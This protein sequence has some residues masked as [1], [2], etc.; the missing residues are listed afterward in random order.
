I[1]GGDVKVI[2]DA[3]TTINSELTKTNQIDASSFQVFMAL[4]GSSDTARETLLKNASEITG[5]DVKVIN[6][7]ITRINSELTTNKMDVSS[8][9]VFMALAGSSDTARAT[10]FA[11]AKKILNGDK[12]FL[13][14]IVSAVEGTNI[15][16]FT[17]VMSILS[18]SFSVKRAE[19]IAGTKVVT[20]MDSAGN[21]INLQINGNPDAADFESTS[22]KMINKAESIVASSGDLSNE[23]NLRRMV[24]ALNSDPAIKRGASSG[25]Q[26]MIS[27]ADK[28]T[29]GILHSVS[30]V[31]KS[32]TIVK[33][34]D[35]GNDRTVMISAT[36]NTE[37][38]N[39]VA[40]AFDNIAVSAGE[41]AGMENVGNLD[42]F[43]VLAETANLRN[44]SL[45]TGENISLQVIDRTT[46]S[47]IYSFIATYDEAALSIILGDGSGNKLQLT[48]STIQNDDFPVGGLFS[49]IKKE[50][51]NYTA[52]QLK[53]ADLSDR[54]T[55]QK[56]AGHLND[57]MMDG[58]LYGK[59]QISAS[60]FK[61]GEGEVPL[62]T[63]TSTVA[64]VS[65]GMTVRDSSGNAAMITL[66][67]SQNRDILD[68]TMF[69]GSG[70]AVDALF[71]N[72]AKAEQIVKSAGDLSKGAA[73]RKIAEALDRSDIDLEFDKKQNFYDQ[74]SVTIGS[75][76]VSLTSET[77]SV[78]SIFKDASG[79]AVLISSTGDRED[80]NVFG[81][82]MYDI[83]A[84]KPLISGAD[85]VTNKEGMVKLLYNARTKLGEERQIG[86][87]VV[88]KETGAVLQGGVKGDDIAVT[89]SVGG[90]TGP[91][92]VTSFEW[93]DNKRIL[94]AFASGD[95]IKI[96]NNGSIEIASKIIMS[97]A[98]E[99]ANKGYMA[100]VG[101]ITGGVAVVAAFVGGFFTVGVTWAAIPV[102]IGSVLTGTMIGAAGGYFIMGPALTGFQ[103]ATI[104]GEGI[105]KGIGRDSLEFS[106]SHTLM[107][108]LAN[109]AAVNG[110]FSSFV[111]ESANLM[112]CFVDYITFGAATSGGAFEIHKNSVFKDQEMKVFAG[113]LVMDI[114]LTAGLGAFVKSIIRGSGKAISKFSIRGVGTAVAKGYRVTRTGIAAMTF[115]GVVSGTRKVMASRVVKMV[116][117]GKAVK[118]RA[119]SNISTQIRNVKAGW[120]NV[121]ARMKKIGEVG[122]VQFGIL[123]TTPF[124][125]L[126]RAA[127]GVA[128]AAGHTLVFTAGA[129]STL[130]GGIRSFLP[131]LGGV[132][133]VRGILGDSSKLFMQGWRGSLISTATSTLSSRLVQM[134]GAGA[135]HVLSGER[136]LSAR[137]AA[138]WS[139]LA[140][141]GF[142]AGLSVI[143]DVSVSELYNSGD[144]FTVGISIFFI[145]L[146][147][148]GS[149]K[150]M[151]KIMNN[152][153]SGARRY[154]VFG[155]PIRVAAKFLGG[156]KYPAVFGGKNIFG[157]VKAGTKIWLRTFSAEAA[158]NSVFQIGI[159]MPITLTGMG[160]FTQPLMKSM[161]Y[162]QDNISYI[163][164]WIGRA[165]AQM[166]WQ[167]GEQDIVSS[168]KNNF[169]PMFIVTFHL[170]G[171]F[172][173]AM[174]GHGG[175]AA[176]ESIN[177]GAMW[178]VGGP[179]MMANNVLIRNVMKLARG[180]KNTFSYI[181]G[182][183]ERSIVSRGLGSVWE[184]GIK[185][186]L[187]GLGL[188]AVGI[189]A[190]TAEYLV[191]MFDFNG[192]AN[193]RGKVGTTET[194]SDN[195]M[196][197]VRSGGSATEVAKTLSGEGYNNTAT[198]EQAITLLESGENVQAATL[199][200]EFATSNREVIATTV[201]TTDI[202]IVETL[203]EIN[204][205]IEVGEAL[206]GYTDDLETLTSL[207]VDVSF[208]DLGLEEVRAIGSYMS[209]NPLAKVDLS[210]GIESLAG[211]T[212][213]VGAALSVSDVSI[214]GRL[215]NAADISVRAME[216]ITLAESAGPASIRN[217]T[218]NMSMLDIGGRGK[219]NLSQTIANT[220]LASFVDNANR[221]GL[222][223]LGVSN[224]M[225]D[226]VKAMGVSTRKDFANSILE[227]SFNLERDDITQQISLLAVASTLQT[228]ASDTITETVLNDLGTSLQTVEASN[229]DRKE[230]AQE[231]KS[232]TGT[233]SAKDLGKRVKGIA[234]GRMLADNKAG[235]AKAHMEELG[236]NERVIGLLTGREN[237]GLA[238]AVGIA[239][240]NATIIDA[241]SVNDND[242]ARAIERLA[243]AH[244]TDI[245]VQKKLINAVLPEERAKR[246]EGM[247]TELTK[248]NAGRES[249][250]MA[251]SMFAQSFYVYST[252]GGHHFA[253]QLEEALLV[254]NADG[255]VDSFSK[256]ETGIMRDQKTL[257]LSQDFEKAGGD[258]R[259][260]AILKAY[261]LL[262]NK[263]VGA[264]EIKGS[265][266]TVFGRVKDRKV[267]AENLAAILG[268]NAANDFIARI[269]A[270]SNNFD[271]NDGVFQEIS[272]A[273]KSELIHN[274]QLFS[275]DKAD[276]VVKALTELGI[277]ELYAV[278]D[279]EIAQVKTYLLEK[280]DVMQGNQAFIAYMLDENNVNNLSDGVKTFLAEMSGQNGMLEQSLQR[281]TIMNSV[282]SKD[283]ET[284]KSLIGKRALDLSLET[285]ISSDVKLLM[286][287][288][289]PDQM[290]GDFEGQGEDLSYE[291]STL[292]GK[293]ITE[294]ISKGESVLTKRKAKKISDT[295]NK[296]R[297]EA[298]KKSQE[299][300]I[301]QAKYEE[302]LNEEKKLHE[303]QRKLIGADIYKTAV[304]AERILEGEIQNIEKTF[305]L[306]ISEANGNTLRDKMISYVT[307]LNKE[308]KVQELK[309]LKEKVSGY[310]KS[311]TAEWKGEG[312]FSTE[313]A[314]AAIM[315]GIVIED[316]KIPYREQLLAA[317]SMIEGNRIAELATGEGK[318]I[319]GWMVNYVR[320]LSGKGVI[321]ASS[322]SDLAE[323]GYGTD[324]KKG[325]KHILGDI[326]GLNVGLVTK[327]TLNEERGSNYNTDA[328]GNKIDVTYVDFGQ[329]AFDVI[330]DS[331]VLSEKNKGGRYIRTKE[332]DLK[333]IF[334][335]ID[336]IDSVLIDQ[337]LTSFIMSGGQGAINLEDKIKTMVA[338]EVQKQL[339]LEGTERQEAQKD[340]GVTARKAEEGF[341]MRYNRTDGMVSLSKDKAK[342]NE[343]V[344]NYAM[345]F[346]QTETRQ[347]IKR[348]LQNQNSSLTLEEI[349][350]AF[351]ALAEKAML[352]ILPSETTKELSK[353]GMRKKDILSDIKRAAEADILYS[354][355]RDYAL[356]HGEIILVS[357]TTGFT[358]E[359]Q[360]LQDNL[361][362]FLEAKEILR[363][364]GKVEGLEMK[365]GS[366]TS[367]SLTARDVLTFFGDVS[368]MTG[369]A[370]S[371]RED[372]ALFKDIY[373]LS[374][375]NI[376]RNAVDKRENRPDEIYFSEGERSEQLKNKI[377]EAVNNDRPVLIQVMNMREADKLAKE[378]SEWKID[379]NGAET[380]LSEGKDFQVYDAR[381]ERT[382]ENFKK[383]AAKDG[384]ITIA[385][386]VAG[387][388]TDITPDAFKKSESE[389]AK[390]RSEH[391][392]KEHE[393]LLAI[394]MGFHNN[395]RV[396]DQFAGRAG[397][398][399]E[400]GEFVQMMLIEKGSLDLAKLEKANS[401]YAW[402]HFQTAN[403]VIFKALAIA[404][405][406]AGEGS[407]ET[408]KTEEVISKEKEVIVKAV[409]ETQN[410]LGR[411]SIRKIRSSMEQG[412]FL[413]NFQLKMRDERNRLDNKLPVFSTVPK[414]ISDLVSVSV[415]E[416]TEN[417]KVNI[418]KLS[419]KLKQNTGLTLTEEELSI[420]KDERENL[421]EDVTENLT[422]LL[423]RHY[424]RA[425][426]EELI[427]DGSRAFF[428]EAEAIR[429]GER[430]DKDLQEAF[431]DAYKI[432]LDHISSVY[433]DVD[434]VSAF[435]SGEM[436]KAQE[437]SKIVDDN[438]VGTY[439]NISAI[440]KTLG[441]AS[442]KEKDA[443][444]KVIEKFTP[445]Q[446]ETVQKVLETDVDNAIIGLQELVT[447]DQENRTKHELLIQ[448]LEVIYDLVAERYKVQERLGDKEF[449][450]QV[451]APKK[452]LGQ[453]VRE[454]IF[455]VKTAYAGKEFNRQAVV[456]Q[457]GSATVLNVTQ[458]EK[459]A[460]RENVLK[461]STIVPDIKT[462]TLS[463]GQEVEIG[464]FAGTADSSGIT[465]DDIK[466]AVLS[467]D[468]IKILFIY[469]PPTEEDVNDAILAVLEDQKIMDQVSSAP[470]DSSAIISLNVKEPEASVVK[471]F[472]GEITEGI[473]NLKRDIEIAR[474]DAAKYKNMPREA[475]AKEA[476]EEISK[477]KVITKEGEYFVQTE[478][479]GKTI[480]AKKYLDEFETRM[481]TEQVFSD[482]SINVPPSIMSIFKYWLNN[483]KE[484]IIGKTSSLASITRSAWEDA[485]PYIKAAIL[486]LAAYAVVSAILE[487]NIPA[488]I[489]ALGASLSIIP[490][491][492]GLAIRGRDEEEIA[493]MSIQEKAAQVGEL[494]VLLPENMPIEEKAK[495]M[496]GIVASSG[497]LVSAGQTITV[498]FGDKEYTLTGEG[499]SV[500]DMLEKEMTQEEFI[501][502]KE[503][504]DQEFGGMMPYEITY[505]VMK[506]GTVEIS[507]KAAIVFDADGEIEFMSS[508]ETVS[509][510]DN[511]IFRGHTHPHIA[512]DTTEFMADAVSMMIRE[513]IYGK[514]MTEYMVERAGPGIFQMRALTRT[515]DEFTISTIVNGE[516]TQTEAI[517]L[518]I[519]AIAALQKG[520]SRM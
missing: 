234:V 313:E 310:L 288:A 68:K 107:N 394:S 69:T 77:M 281:L 381:K 264:N 430:S 34:V 429:R 51:Q 468:N 436:K 75:N 367:R 115:K 90:E 405:D 81:L 319:V 442:L 459:D 13:S 470:A 76:T 317:V 460:I 356:R 386:A 9:Q 2:N 121:T 14:N 260:F 164:N 410:I 201:S 506:D 190:S 440:K 23:E 492:G 52:N 285:G 266:K 95:Q 53:Y 145:A 278:S 448:D 152:A 336:E 169:S 344:S 357:D 134:A 256:R 314:L 214:K 171:P 377:E 109:N 71:G 248:T 416:A 185:E 146:T 452:N 475:K 463:N 390:Y 284:L 11:N 5:G 472:K 327:N 380:I 19:Q 347:K 474:K 25:I 504:A 253:T 384:M 8:F 32:L 247:I 228:E 66:S 497:G 88:Q 97:Q 206:Q 112:V 98:A 235:E 240:N 307:T 403:P 91:Q 379:K 92:L 111:F 411:S 341:H 417:G 320:A 374:I 399:G 74:I 62:Y 351:D 156:L 59:D 183:S 342:R 172:I 160:K 457:Q 518:D 322:S 87:S 482:I 231:L 382:A 321:S 129:V 508:T 326:M 158:L 335:T 67:V 297:E 445:E 337:A 36:V 263:D 218:S 20:L 114:V 110:G 451:E 359:G 485:N 276:T 194:R 392:G 434:H 94:N 361:H 249:Y 63:F 244:A 78:S 73:L 83:L 279:K 484:R 414:S 368:G 364:D 96:S 296:K 16:S 315:M 215:F 202:A 204:T 509:T 242:T 275:K 383:E 104:N 455:G 269:N 283:V 302:Y 300:G 189:K 219:I 216:T 38:K 370:T 178:V 311:K 27:I 239:L 1:T 4:A 299:K 227:R 140:Y 41:L 173:G 425:A 385:T 365:G 353:E 363:A 477:V 196:N 428:V 151:G 369:T 277:Y 125:V 82:I 205:N 331:F 18:T 243:I 130:L 132:A 332:S 200:G 520:I 293:F 79:N 213:M 305:N 496:E 246:L 154:S 316:G 422:D 517:D 282:G 495:L 388:G 222:V 441:I 304:D 329:L 418:E 137:N 195:I 255:L 7:A 499:E 415:G 46:N 60:V 99:K 500:L 113:F 330:H 291:Q 93:T 338:Y 161:G 360:R 120:L 286:T 17:V 471:I 346:R 44:T 480:P 24:T 512:T 70:T 209:N 198:F 175:K 502:V 501:K 39:A 450:K 49:T 26:T 469:I 294:S 273:I 491:A 203:A 433:M 519:T 393:G 217:L 61:S 402:E 454:R 349:D 355:N 42:Q 424:T 148:V 180:M 153:A 486:S 166:V 409:T 170:L 168:I 58:V 122:S 375:D 435:A 80:N 272:D 493:E 141:T 236:V 257:D 308:G 406:N 117:F 85:D 167:F 157:S 3:I 372:I 439:R 366:G 423:T 324:A 449:L 510:D 35:V 489:D 453:R 126:G 478:L 186:P 446:R 181:S 174:L 404:N 184:E 40:Y 466:Q 187:I 182:G 147:G 210:S 401:L 252:I 426:Q 456:A 352:G 48:A 150:V 437:S 226:A 192:N 50:M 55:F 419:K 232:Q 490:L 237:A 473:D 458:E 65:L 47:I 421:P 230:L 301:S 212:A 303:K 238:K 420:T 432:F 179:H 350:G 159:L 447:H 483:V 378:M 318:T 199:L 241:F 103:K 396:R 274:H 376:G 229:L 464:V 354:L 498:N 362:Q 323:E 438:T 131:G 371:F 136:I 476:L 254:T 12:V 343:I 37:T 29:G 162:D 188:Q 124:G 295:L 251:M 333:D 197:I 488:L 289:H 407:S 176:G 280:E 348:V 261:G 298:Y 101:A 177:A 431:N 271:A 245:G 398:N 135:K 108:E 462:V 340:S 142:T 6:D 45:G 30:I 155:K 328:E 389:R 57:R 487:I 233:F 139:M 309:E 86:I 400:N 408:E 258:V 133:K 118:V 72:M 15:N 225:Q 312:R 265:L 268:A 391:Y 220:A 250:K 443:A 465:E 325:A 461:K 395:V 479:Y 444:R 207:G 123:T 387:R 165:V 223:Y 31:G 516:V 28:N 259:T 287:E 143:S 505:T 358:Q 33:Y 56:Y 413:F 515:G 144:M 54:G 224:N 514:P 494:N 138:V 105:L 10:L 191:E 412:E 89:R 211:R 127:K 21:G 397:R 221:A 119:A 163:K 193:F 84:T 373:G 22:S 507:E 102:V 513:A 339:S 290:M 427:E 267:F 262:V 116:N 100:V 43:Q 467:A 208:S 345:A 149:G 128:T 270:T 64:A 306:K 503:V 511:V 106:T 481:I 292:L 334:V